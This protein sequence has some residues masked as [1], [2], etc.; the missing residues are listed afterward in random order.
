MPIYSFRCPDCGHAFDRLVPL[1]LRDA[2]LCP[3][4]KAQALRQLAAPGVTIG[5]IG[6]YK[7]GH[8]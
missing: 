1:D 6:A 3:H 4:C 5:G 8:F 7:P 2:Q